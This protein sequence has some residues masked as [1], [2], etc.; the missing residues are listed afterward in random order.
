M[1]VSFVFIELVRVWENRV[2]QKDVAMDFWEGKKEKE[3]EK[4]KK[5]K[6]EKK[7]EKKKW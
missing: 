2:T 1:R 4:K 7:G 5:G 6:R 3:G